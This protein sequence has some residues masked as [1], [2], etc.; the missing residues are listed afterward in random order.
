MV[1]KMTCGWRGDTI[2]IFKMTIDDGQMT[3]GEIVFDVARVIIA[4]KCNSIE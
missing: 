2:I 3:I 4:A 1:S